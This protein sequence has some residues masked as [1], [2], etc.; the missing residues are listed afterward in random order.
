MDCVACGNPMIA[1]E[2]DQVEIDYCIECGGIWLD[3]GELEI[4]LEDP[5]KVENVLRHA[6]PSP[7]TS[8][9]F[10]KCPICLKK[11]EEIE[12]DGETEIYIDRCKFGH[13][14]WFDRGELEEVIRMIDHDESSKVA[15]LLKDVF[16]K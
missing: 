6:I 16:R 12:L 7:G 4:L 13:G 9:S 14:L 1:L 3:S 2:V 10:R 5:R 8:E 11:M 15:K